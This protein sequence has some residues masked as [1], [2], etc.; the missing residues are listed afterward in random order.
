MPQSHDSDSDLALFSDSARSLPVSASS[1]EYFDGDDPVVHEK[2]K[3]HEKISEHPVRKFDDGDIDVPPSQRSSRPRFSYQIICS[4]LIPKTENR[5]FG[6]ER[7]KK[8]AL[9][10]CRKRKDLKEDFHY[11]SR[12]KSKY[13]QELDPGLLNVH[14]KTSRNTCSLPIPTVGLSDK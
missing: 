5:I 9:S 2:F 8:T 11:Y 3:S 1:D 6:M 14:M 7:N 10:Q 13:T 4:A 12:S